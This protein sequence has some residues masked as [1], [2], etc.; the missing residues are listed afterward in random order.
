MKNHATC[1]LTPTF[2]YQ[3]PTDVFW[4][5]PYHYTGQTFNHR[6]QLY[7]TTFNLLSCKWLPGH[8][9]T[10]VFTWWVKYDN[11]PQF[12]FFQDS[13]TLCSVIIPTQEK[14][15]LS[16][17]R[18]DTDKK[19]YSPEHYVIIKIFLST[20]DNSLYAYNQ[21]QHK[22][23]QWSEISPAHKINPPP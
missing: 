20:T 6:K 4:V 2:Y 15:S 9:S 12:L 21:E 17:L 3:W 22:E 8:Q 18:L 5:H 10:H 7:L 16:L 19:L 11:R 1:I 23:N 13:P 14:F